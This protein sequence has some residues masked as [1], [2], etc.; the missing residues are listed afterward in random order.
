[1]IGLLIILPACAKSRYSGLGIHLPSKTPTTAAAV[2]IEEPVYHRVRPGES[3]GSISRKY[4]VTVAELVN[5]NKLSDPNKLSV[6]QRI[7]IPGTRGE[8]WAWP[9]LG[10]EIF[11]RFG[12]N[13]GTHR[14]R[15]I[16]IR[17]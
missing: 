5:L 15:G 7:L 14:H 12:V 17:G 4:D 2:E 8:N 13:R 16:D 11:F 6:N 9:V 3:L 1:M 10:G